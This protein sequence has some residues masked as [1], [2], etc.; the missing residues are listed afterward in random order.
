MTF[1]FIAF[2]PISPCGFSTTRF[3]SGT[4]NRSY[5][6]SSYFPVVLRPPKQVQVNLIAATQCRKVRRVAEDF[7]LRH[8]VSAIAVL[9]DFL[10]NQ[11]L[12]S[13]GFNNSFRV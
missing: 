4:R 5:A 11:D 10:L 8:N 7:R 6:S 2:T 3:L 9:L 13:A 1:I 12:P